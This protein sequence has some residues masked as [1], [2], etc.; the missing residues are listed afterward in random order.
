MNRHPLD[1]W[2]LIFG[3]FLSV[4]GIAFLV[5]AEPISFTNG[6]TELLGWAVPLLVVLAGVALILPTLRRRSAAAEQG[7]PAEPPDTI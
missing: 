6:L 3:L 7:P 1:P 4:L 2:S 5:P